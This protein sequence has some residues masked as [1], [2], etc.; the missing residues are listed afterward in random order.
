MNLKIKKNISENNC[1]FMT[2]DQ[3]N[4][5]ENGTSKPEIVKL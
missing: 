5:R 1:C 3:C 4:I 2:K